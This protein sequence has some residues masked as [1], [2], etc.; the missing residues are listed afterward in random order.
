MPVRVPSPTW[1][2]PSSPI[3]GSSTETMRAPATGRGSYR[4]NVWAPPGR[5]A[6]VRRCCPPATPSAPRTAST[7]SKCLV[8]RSTDCMSCTI[9]ITTIDANLKAQL[10]F[11]LLWRAVQCVFFRNYCRLILAVQFFLIDNVI[12]DVYCGVPPTSAR[13]QGVTA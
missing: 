13:Q 3:R 7:E 1:E 8:S 5:T 9:L 11:L 4:K 12:C 2:R 6:A 10:F